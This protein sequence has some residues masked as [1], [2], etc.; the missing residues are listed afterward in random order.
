LN[1]EL[2]KLLSSSSL[3]CPVFL[4]QVISSRFLPYDTIPTDAVLGLDEDTVLSTAEVRPRGASCWWA[5][6]PGAVGVF[7]GLSP[8]R[9]SPVSRWTSPSRCG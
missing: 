2:L 3:T 5:C 8:R 4:L 6:P 9:F 7:T 1:Q